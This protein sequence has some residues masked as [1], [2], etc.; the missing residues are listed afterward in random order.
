MSIS[1][2]D[3][4]LF[5]LIASLTQTLHDVGKDALRDLV[6]LL[7]LDEKGEQVVAVYNRILYRT[8][9]QEVVQS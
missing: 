7:P 3:S 8:L 9:F 4:L 5:H 6:M 1:E 2:S